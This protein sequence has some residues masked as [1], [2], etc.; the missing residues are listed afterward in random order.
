MNSELMNDLVAFARAIDQL[1]TRG[2]KMDRYGRRVERLNND[3][4]RA[5]VIKYAGAFPTII[6][7]GGADTAEQAGMVARALLAAI[8]RDASV[9]LGDQGLPALLFDLSDWLID[10]ADAIYT[11]VRMLGAAPPD[12]RVWFKPADNVD[13]QAHLLMSVAKPPGASFALNLR[14]DLHAV[15]FAQLRKRIRDAFMASIGM[16]TPGAAIAMFKRNAAQD[17]A[18]MGGKS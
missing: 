12:A 1:W 16:S 5:L 9:P 11:E 2:Q 7:D 18:E 6:P 15:P 10:E 17:A 14:D 13:R 4:L 8:E 3:A